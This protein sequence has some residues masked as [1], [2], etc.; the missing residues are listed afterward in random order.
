MKL[1]KSF[2]KIGMAVLALT[3]ATGCATVDRGSAQAS[4]QAPEAARVEIVSVPYN[5]ALPKYVV[6]VEPFNY[7]AA[8][9]TSGAADGSNVYN[10]PGGQVG[11]GVSAQLTTA[12]TRAGNISVVELDALTKNADGTYSTKLQEGEIGPFI[13]R[14]T[15]TEFNETADLSG[16]KRGG[17]AGSLGT[18]LSIIGGATGSSTLATTGGVTAAANPTVENEKVKRSGMVGLDLKLVDGR[19]NRIVRGYPAQGSFTTVSAKSGMSV[20]GVGGADTEFAASALGQATRQ[21]MNTA[22]QETASALTAVQK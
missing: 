15:V 22:V 14:G 10:Q 20:F 9:I 11:A 3:V 7:G 8:G 19:T 4:A 12:L 16:Q 18:G 6:A 17:S 13:V 5:A 1:S 2:M 21:A